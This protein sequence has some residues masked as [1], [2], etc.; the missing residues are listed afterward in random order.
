MR[1]ATMQEPPIVQATLDPTLIPGIYES[2]DQWC[3]YCHATN[4]C[5]AYR[6]S[7]DIQSGKQDIHRPL[8]ERLFEGMMFL[9]RLCDAEGRPTPEIDAILSDDPRE[10][11]VIEVNDPLERMA[12]RYGQ[13]SDAYLMS[14]PDFP[15][16]MYARVSG[17]TPFEVFAWYHRLISAK[18]YRALLSAAHAARGEAG[19]HREALMAA[20]VALIGMDRSL[21]ALAAMTAEDDDPRHELMQAQLRR[22]R[23]EVEARFPD[24]RGVVRPGLDDGSTAEGT[25]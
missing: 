4:R 1:E 14:R 11:L 13:V 20:K 8:A 3:M 9:K 25:S 15:F 16:E 19:R 2:C 22:L 7:P 12:G 10:Q 5:L 21:D 6:S 23:R 17:P 18:I 24:A